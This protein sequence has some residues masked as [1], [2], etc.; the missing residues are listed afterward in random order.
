MTQYRDFEIVIFTE[1]YDYSIHFALSIFSLGMA[2][3]VPWGVWV[4]HSLSDP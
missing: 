3:M 4:A 1:N 2:V